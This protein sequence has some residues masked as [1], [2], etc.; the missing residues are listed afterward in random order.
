MDSDDEDSDDEESEENS[1]EED[2]SVVDM[3][4][5][6]AAEESKTITKNSPGISDSSDDFLKSSGK[7]SFGTVVVP[8]GKDVR[9]LFIPKEAL[10]PDKSPLFFSEDDPELLK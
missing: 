6:M 4:R 2:T 10:V 1:D 5:P 8:D 9:D 7:F 3:K